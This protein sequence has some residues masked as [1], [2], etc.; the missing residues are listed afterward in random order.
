MRRA[1][2]FTVI[3]LLVVLT[4]IAILLSIAAPRYVAHLDNAKEL[5]L[6]HNLKAMRE[7]MDRYHAD[8]GYP[9]GTLQDVVAA[10]YLREIPEDPFTQRRDSWKF[11]QATQ[12]DSS[13]VATSVGSGRADVFSGAQGAARDGSRYAS[14]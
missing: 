7:A 9:P 4:A 12:G 8:R 13:F 11:V 5:V 14:W 10:R 1:R 2:G 3:E 6:R